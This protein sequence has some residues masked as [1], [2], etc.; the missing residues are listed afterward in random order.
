MSTE[1]INSIPSQNINVFVNNK[2]RDLVYGFG[3]GLANLGIG[4]VGAAALAVA[5]PIYC[6][7]IGASANGVVGGFTGL[8]VG[9]GVGLI[10]SC[11]LL[12]GGVYTCVTQVFGGLINTPESVG[13]QCGGKEWD[14]DE[15]TWKLCGLDDEAAHVLKLTEE[16]I[17]KEADGDQ[18]NASK[19]VSDSELY[20]ILGV[21]TN[22]SASE[23]K[24]A[25]YIKARASHPDRNLNDPEA[26]ARF[27]KIGEA[28][29][30]LSDDRLR[31]IYDQ[32]GKD[33]VE[34][35][36]RV[37]ANQLFQF[38][39]G[40]EK[41]EHIVGELQVLS[42]IQNVVQQEGK[43]SDPKVTAFRQRKRE[44]QC[45]VNLASRLDEFT[46]GYEDS[47]KSSV[48]TEAKE[49]A[50][51]RFGA[52][53][54][55]FVGSVYIEKANA[56]LSALGSIQ[57]GL[58]C[59]GRG[60]SDAVNLT[61]TGVGV[62]VSASKLYATQKDADNKKDENGE[63]I[64][65]KN[66][67]GV[68]LHDD[69]VREKVQAVSA[70]MITLV[71]HLTRMDVVKTLDKAIRKVLDDKTVDPT[72]LKNRATA[73][74]AIGEIYCNIGSKNEAPL[75]EFIAR[76][77]KDINTH[78]GMAPKEG[79]DKRTEEDNDS[80]GHTSGESNPSSYNSSPSQDNPMRG[81]CTLSDVEFMPIRELK[82]H[83]VHLGG[84]PSRCLEK[85]DLKKCLS[86]LMIDNMSAP[87]VKEYIVLLSFSS[88]DAVTQEVL[89]EAAGE[90]DVMRLR[91]ILKNVLYGEQ[92]ICTESV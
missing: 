33:G 58:S 49:L 90:S 34:G 83:I 9:V 3:G 75:Q 39:F 48:E 22:A 64:N 92:E 74:L 68:S 54:L 35:T 51:N 13:A 11:A 1:L 53:L 36:A 86:I 72:K 4:E 82:A 16:D 5:A 44:V 15:E 59:L 42:T 78:S 67:F 19:H 17:M 31:F 50:D 89:C 76:V 71:W 46:E 29:Q 66:K 61:A 63:Y 37:D 40:S 27:Q 24:K 43:L 69:N 84:D 91:E 12:V 28:Y 30:I 57:S 60:I 65:T 88:S 38:I 18:S 26:H 79:E 73:L 55:A 14:E 45:A 81:G 85:R 62:T 47:F 32:R 20:D 87:E 23:I 52:T 21:E 56:R 77:E 2:P 70:G 10:G 7:Y 80:E 41:F 6:T 25:Y 8:G